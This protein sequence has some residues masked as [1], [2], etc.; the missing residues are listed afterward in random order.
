MNSISSN[1]EK[2]INNHVNNFFNNIKDR[3]S[4]SLDEN[5]DAY[6]SLNDLI[7]LWDEWTTNEKPAPKVPEVTK[8]VNQVLMD[9]KKEKSVSKAKSSSQPA[10]SGCQ[11]VSS[12]GDNKG[13]ACGGKIS[14]SSTTKKYCS[15]HLKQEKENETKSPPKESAKTKKSK[16]E[17]TPSTK[18]ELKKKIEERK[19]T[20][21]VMRNQWGNYEHSD[22]HIILDKE[23][24]MA[25]GKQ[26]SDGK[27]L[28]L[29]ADDIEMCKVLN[30]KYKIPDTI[31]SSSSKKEIVYESD[32]EDIY[33]DEDELDD[34]ELDD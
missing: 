14:Q 13:K 34:E 22:T 29:S 2:L 5:G 21:N 9:E 31:S 32:D 18:E 4:D 28:P 16:D 1:I 33:D 11:Y 19:P 3:F 26:S 8:T 15:K 24:H 7:N 12:R 6:I 17:F 20:I 27:I 23:T 25:V 10:E 30:F